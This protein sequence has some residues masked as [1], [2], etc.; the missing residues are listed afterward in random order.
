MHRHLP[1]LAEVISV[2]IALSHEHIQRK[3]TIHQDTCRDYITVTF[4]DTLIAP[5]DQ[6]H[7]IDTEMWNVLM[8]EYKYDKNVSQSDI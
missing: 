6:Y 1:A 5:D 4:Q 7:L 2:S 3:T 8:V